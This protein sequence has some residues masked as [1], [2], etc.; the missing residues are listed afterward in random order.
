MAKP[1]GSSQNIVAAIDAGS[2]AMRLAIGRVDGD[3]SVHE[4]EALREPVRLGGDAFSRGRLSDATIDAA[5]AAFERFA[6]RIREHEAG[7]VRAV[8]TSAAREASNS[9]TLVSRIRKATGIR[10]EVINGLEEAQLVFAGVAGVV[11]L[12][13]RAAF[14]I[15]MGGGS[16]E[17][18]VARDG[19][20]LGCE[21][22]ALGAV[23]LLAQINDLGK[24]EVDVEEM[25]APLRGA[26]AGLVKAEIEDQKPDVCIGTGG[27]LECLGRLRGPLLGKEKLGKVKLADLDLMI[28]KL[29]AMTPAQRIEEL[30][31]RPDRADVVAIAAIVLR[32]VMQDAGVARVL[33]PGVG[34]NQGLLRQVADRLREPL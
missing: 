20:A 22:L 25:I 3:G 30:K 31:L 29:L 34:L 5:V 18:T 17:I 4:I 19:L 2:N 9:G 26:A 27:N 21:T 8:A 14:L 10:L 1:N 15:D 24:S 12:A 16:V 6:E 7:R 11:D 23:R 33:T 32:M 28:D 13:G